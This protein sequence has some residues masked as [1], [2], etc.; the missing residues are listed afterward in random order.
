MYA[1]GC[2]RMWILQRTHSCKLMYC[3][4]PGCTWHTQRIRFVE[5]KILTNPHHTYDDCI[6]IYVK[7]VQPKDFTWSLCFTPLGGLFPAWFSV[8]PKEWSDSWQLLCG[9]MGPTTSQQT[10]NDVDLL[11]L[12]LHFVGPGEGCGWKSVANPYRYLGKDRRWEYP[13]EI[14]VGVFLSGIRVL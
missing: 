4:H 6:N 7:P 9:T 3:C 5:Q 2:I 8:R 14:S 12:P 10:T 13:S 1:L 11:G